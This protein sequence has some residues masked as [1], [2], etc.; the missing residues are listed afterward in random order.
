ML[1]KANRVKTIHSS[2]AIE[3]NTLSEGQVADIINGKNVMA[4]LRQ[5]QEV[6]NAI[7]VY[8]E[9]GRLDPFSEKDLLRAHSIIMKAIATDAGRYRSSAVGVFGETGLIHLAP[10]PAMVPKLMNDLFDWLKTSTDH[11]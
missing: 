9:Y 4:P 3:G 6:K 10:S 8:D 11:L 2:L 7:N 5:I 1:R